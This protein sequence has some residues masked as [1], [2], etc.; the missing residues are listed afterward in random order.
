M[1]RSALEVTID[2]LSRHAKLGAKQ[3]QGT[4]EL[5]SIGL[6]SLKYILVLLEIQDSG[7]GFT[8]DPDTMGSWKTVDDLAHSMRHESLEGSI[9]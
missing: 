4:D 9:A 5:A 3:I 7:D 8:V 6:D 1:A 2:V